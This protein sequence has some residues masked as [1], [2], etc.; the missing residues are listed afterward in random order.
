M[1]PRLEHA[2]NLDAKQNA[3]GIKLDNKIEGTAKN[4]AFFTLKGSQN[5]FLNNYTLPVAKP[6]QI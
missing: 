3:K 4:P 6:V 1:T 5:K 2:I